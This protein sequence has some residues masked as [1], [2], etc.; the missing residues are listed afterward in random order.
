MDFWPSG[1]QVGSLPNKNGRK[2]KADRE[3]TTQRDGETYPV[4]E[5]RSLTAANLVR[6]G[7]GLEWSFLLRDGI[8]M[9]I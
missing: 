1:S 2:K 9:L 5:H 4:V 6:E 3:K 7:E 8:S